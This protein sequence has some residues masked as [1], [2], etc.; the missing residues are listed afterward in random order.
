MGIINI[1]YMLVALFGIHTPYVGDL[2]NNFPGVYEFQQAK[3]IAIAISIT[4]HVDYLMHLQ[5]SN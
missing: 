3:P 1:K 5:R 2:G 4:L